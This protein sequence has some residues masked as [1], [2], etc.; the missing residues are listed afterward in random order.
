MMPFEV[1]LMWPLSDDCTIFRLALP[2]LPLE[3]LPEPL[4]VHL[5]F[6]AESIDAILERLTMLRGQMRPTPAP[7]KRN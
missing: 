1:D 4:K 7:D 5:D 2:P 6:D 3:N